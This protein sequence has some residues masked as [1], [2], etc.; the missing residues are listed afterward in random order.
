M[1]ASTRLECLPGTRVPIIQVIREWITN[2][3]ADSS[4]F[5][6]HG[7]AGSG[8]STLMTTVA[9][10]FME[11]GQLGAFLFFD[12]DSSERNDPKLV[13]RTLAYQLALFD[14]QIGAKISEA[15]KANPRIIYSPLRFQFLK[16]LVEP[17]SS[18]DVLQSEASIVL[19]LDALDECGSAKDRKELLDLL[20]N[21]SVRLPSALRFICTSRQELDIQK[22]FGG[23]RHVLVREL[24][25][26]SSENYNDI[27][28]FFRHQLSTIRS[29]SDF[30]ALSLDW[31]GDDMVHVLT[32]RAAGLFM[33]V[34][35]VRVHR[36]WT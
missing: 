26:T 4:V 8:K 15:T 30:L 32:K 10:I 11:S 16:L 2:P 34:N 18:P 6:L 35:C 9:H 19:V 28:S 5:W 3:S 31:P 1:D 27:V 23:K 12:R 33:G 22:A 17:L 14:S 36:R 7:L 13:I 29:Y 20:L 25:I 24:D 21:E